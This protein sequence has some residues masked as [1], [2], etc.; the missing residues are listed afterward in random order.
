MRARSVASRSQ[1]GWVKRLALVLLLTAGPILCLPAIR[2]IQLLFTQDLVVDR[3]TEAWKAREKLI[4]RAKVFVT[5]RPVIRQLDLSDPPTAAVPFDRTALTECQYVPKLTTGT[6]PKFDCRLADGSL[7]KIKYGGTPERL[8]EV[9]ATRLLAALGFGADEVT[10]LQRVRCQGCPPHPFVTRKTAEWFLAGWLV[11]RLFGRESREFNWVS[12]ERKLPGRAIEADGFEGWDWSELD[13]VD[14]S[15]GGATR[16][17]LDALRLMAIFLGHWDTKA[18]NQRLLC[19]KGEGESDPSAPC[20]RPLLMIHDVG[21]TF[22]PGKVEETNWAATPIWADAGSCTVKLP[23]RDGTFD[24]I[25]ISEAGRVLMAGR[26]RQLSE[27]QIATIFQSAGF[28][29]PASGET[30]GDVTL[31]VKA[32]RDKVRQID[33]RPACRG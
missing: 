3:H 17:E 26:L 15:A 27:T 22:G 16:A 10:L 9:A 12:V 30:N 21:A 23:H 32:F 11:D 1:P 6:T 7:I 19:E 14:A 24:T 31:W 29:D 8:A 33:N 5:P 4:A 20:E 13:R 18:R 2:C 25:R 28:P